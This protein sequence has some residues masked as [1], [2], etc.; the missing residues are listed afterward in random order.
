MQ[1]N[2]IPNTFFNE[3]TNYYN[4]FFIENNNDVWDKKQCTIFGTSIKSS[5]RM[6]INYYEKWTTISNNTITIKR[7]CQ[8]LARYIINV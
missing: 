2:G 5:N 3:T 7:K 4:K 1:I 6:A 8:E